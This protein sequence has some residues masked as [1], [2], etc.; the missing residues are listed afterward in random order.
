MLQT[1]F[2]EIN[3]LS[4]HIQHNIIDDN[5][6]TI[7][8][9]H[10]SLGSVKLWRD[11]P[12]N[13]GNITNCNVL[14]YDREGHGN[15]SPFSITE[16][17][18]NYLE[19]GA[20]VLS[21]LIN[22]LNLKKVI[23]FGHSDGATIA[24]HYAAKYPENILATI[25]EGVHIFVEEETLQ[26]IREAKQALETTNL[27]ERV[28]KYHD[29]KTEM[30]FKMWMETWLNPNYRNWNIEKN[31]QNIQSPV[32]IFQ[33]ENDEFGTMKQVEK[34]KANVKSKV[35]DYLISDCG[36]NPHKEQKEFTLEKTNQ[37]IRAYAL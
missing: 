18:V 32:L 27:I 8:F 16:R 2:I 25:V 4:Y 6:P 26:G 20:D 30:L 14:M 3:G 31:I 28:S 9:L 29:D 17:P 15:S 12:E 24:L 7:V 21:Q 22:K 37:F 19:L 10:D 1:D 36:H 11:F 13:L 5:L 35:I 34:I 33:G 23:L